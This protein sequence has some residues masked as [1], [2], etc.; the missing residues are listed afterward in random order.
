MKSSVLSQFCK[1]ACGN[2]AI[3]SALMIPI[4]MLVVGGA[5]DYVQYG[6]QR[7]QLQKAVDASALAGA[8]RFTFAVTDISEIKSLVDSELDYHIR[9]LSTNQNTKKSS[10]ISEKDSSVKA[11]ITQTTNLNFLSAFL[12]SQVTVTSE[13]VAVGQVNLCALALDEN[14]MNGVRLDKTSKIEAYGCSVFSNSTS[15]ES[16]LVARKSRLNSDLVCSSGGYVGNEGNF[17]TMPIVDCPVYKDPL[18]GQIIYPSVGACDE[19]DFAIGE[20]K[21]ERNKRNDRRRFDEQLLPENTDTSEEVFDE[22]ENDRLDEL[23]FTEFV[24]E[25]GVYCGGLE[26]AGKAK[27]KFDP[28]VYIIK[29]GVLDFHKRSIVRGDGVV[30]FFTGED[31]HIRVE[32]GVTL[33]LIAPSQGLYAGLLLL[34]DPN[35]MNGVEH[36]IKSAMARTL[37]GTVYIPKSKFIIDTNRSVG[38]DSAFTIIVASSIHLLGSPQLF[39]NSK[40]SSTTVPVPSGVGPIGGTVHLRN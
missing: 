24:L 9:R 13:A 29:D 23:D 40:Y 25:P 30:F 5:V 17:S 28:G 20:G 8:R 18:A 15:R 31:A 21:K 32:K 3:V 33:D 12:P 2:V 16:I 1:N 4:L 26:I 7:D 38:E 10:S 36:I 34:E 39:L 27:V 11:S 19:V 22:R 37:L 35:N 14:I 6:N